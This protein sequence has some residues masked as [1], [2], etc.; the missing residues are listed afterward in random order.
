MLRWFGV[1]I[2][3]RWSI[4]FLVGIWLGVMLLEID[5]CVIGGVCVF[6]QFLDV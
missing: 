4:N 6:L 3:G 1:S 5:I 2:Y